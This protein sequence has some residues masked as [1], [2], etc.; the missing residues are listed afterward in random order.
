M[1]FKKIL[2]ILNL[3]LVNSQEYNSSKQFSLSVN[4]FDN[5]YF[6]LDDPKIHKNIYSIDYD[7]IIDCNN[8]TVNLGD[9]YIGT[10]KSTYKDLRYKANSRTKDGFMFTRKVIGID[11]DYEYEI[12]FIRCWNL[13]TVKIDPVELLKVAWI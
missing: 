6:S 7:T 8:H 9:F 13:L 5:N 10:S 2:F 11:I 12:D 1:L 3:L 4:L